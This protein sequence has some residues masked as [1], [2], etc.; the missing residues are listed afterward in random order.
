MSPPDHH[1]G[2]ASAR[3]HRI[4]DNALD[5]VVIIDEHDVI[6]GWNRQAV[7][8]FGW[9]EAEILGHNLATTIVPHQHRKA[10]LA[11]MQRFL[12]HG[13]GALMG[14][15]IETTACNRD[16]REFPIELAISFVGE[17]GRYEFSAFIRDISEQIEARERLRLAARVFEV[18]AEGIMVT[19]AANRIVSTNPA[20][21]EITGYTEEEVL[22]KPPDV[23]SSGRHDR[24]FYEAMWKSLLGTGLWR[25]E[26]WNRRKNG[27]IYP[28]W[29]SVSLVRDD[30]G[31]VINHVG[32]FSD[33]SERHAAHEQMRRL[34][35]FDPLTHLA[36]RALLRERLP[37]LLAESK[38]HQT[39]LL[40]IDLDGF[41]PVNDEH[42]HPVGDQLL[43]QVGE[44]LRRCVRRGDL[45]ARHGGD[46]FIV[47]LNDIV[48]TCHVI[49]VAG[50]ILKALAK[51]YTV[52][53]LSLQL[54]ASLGIGLA[55]DH[56]DDMD[57]LISLADRAMYV[58][59][60]SGPGK[61]AFYGSSHPESLPGPAG[62]SCI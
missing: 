49:H 48:D 18:S 43:E 40:F 28:Q 19:D 56:S 41:K 42:G 29:L 17:P 3:N 21:Q 10:H 8:L 44:R 50:K 23:L 58:A 11:G 53:G 37:Q 47:V 27:E 32:V 24:A 61:W 51:P 31:Q 57:T 16:G 38:G 9:K 34:A 54:S 45:A 2:S 62:T 36:N 1:G 55:P 22:G 20:F 26:I 25:G 59:K 60:E 12:A 33:I 14:R 52:E 46:E 15:R 7:L 30:S 13:P 39:A 35:H 5:A 4:L 6:L